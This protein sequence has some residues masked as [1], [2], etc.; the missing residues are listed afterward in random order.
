M[1]PGRRGE[2]RSARSSTSRSR[3]PS[4]DTRS[5]A[6]YA[7]AEPLS[8]RRALHNSAGPDPDTN[9]APNSSGSTE[10][11]RRHRASGRADPA[12]L[13][14]RPAKPPNQEAYHTVPRDVAVSRREILRRCGEETE[15]QQGERPRTLPSIVRKSH[16]DCARVVQSTKKV[17]RQDIL[18]RRTSVDVLVGVPRRRAVR[19]ERLES[20]EAKGGAGK[21]SSSFARNAARQ[22]GSRWGKE[23]ARESRS[24]CDLL[25]VTSK[26][27]DITRG[28]VPRPST[29]PKIIHVSRSSREDWASSR[30][31]KDAVRKEPP[32]YG[33]IRRRKTSLPSNTAT[34]RGSFLSLARCPKPG[35][36]RERA[37]DV[38]FRTTARHLR[39]P[40]PDA[41][42]CSAT[43]PLVEMRT[44]PQRNAIYAKVSRR[45]LRAVQRGEKDVV[46]AGQ[47]TMSRRRIIENTQDNEA[48]ESRPV[49]DSVEIQR[50][51]PSESLTYPGVD[52][53]AGARRVPGVAGV[54]AR[55]KESGR[56]KSQGRLIENFR[57]TR[58]EID[59]GSRL[60]T[61]LPSYVKSSRKCSAESPPGKCSSKQIKERSNQA[62][63]SASGHAR[64]Y[65]DANSGRSSSPVTTSS[66]FGFCTGKRKVQSTSN[67]GAKAESASA[68]PTWSLETVS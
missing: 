4:R 46:D 25:A 5:E 39:D 8:V 54:A 27:Q 44:N 20:S 36:L 66:I 67:S 53:E 42:Y 38:E 45:T 30:L 48:D 22:R 43:L 12:E 47:R 6:F 3:F 50:E 59:A 64:A 29:L 2:Q 21:S 49:E 13:A 33:R 57:S 65:S 18:R 15:D 17:S 26:L 51:F 55:A 11:A 52:A 61:T 32:V 10:R 63:K 14:P 1:E 16:K 19:E 60:A 7:G 41:P 31:A 37:V 23:D 28:L 9:S 40:V 68:G 58:R 62:R 35:S 56:S 34:L 24:V